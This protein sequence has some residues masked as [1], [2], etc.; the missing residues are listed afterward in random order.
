[1]VN[2]HKDAGCKEQRV[3][4][5]NKREASEIAGINEMRRD[6]ECAK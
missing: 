3:G 6:A 4:K 1:M 5:L 2:A